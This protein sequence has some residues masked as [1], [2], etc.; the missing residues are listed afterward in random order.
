MNNIKAV[1]MDLDGTTLREDLT[2]SDNLKEKINEFEKK[3]IKFFVSTGRSYKSSKPYVE[4]LGLRNETI[5][6]NGA[7][8]VPANCI[9]N[10]IYEQPLSKEVVE[11][12]IDVS[13]S[14][15][16]HLNLYNN[17]DLYVENN[18]K[19][20]IAYA[21]GV[22]IDFI[23]D[24]FDNFIGKTSTKG[25]FIAENRILL[26]LKE[27]LENI[28]SEVNYVFSK[29]NYLEVLNKNVNKGKAVQYVLEKH[30]ISK[31]NAVAFGDQWNDYEML[32]TV[33]YGILMGNAPE[34]LKKKFSKNRITLSNDE[35]GIV[36]MLEKLFE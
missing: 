27:E 28:I 9:N 7:R 8:I 17:D 36:Y 2:I 30:G 11:K 20:A 24:N 16:I 22:G 35:D 18:S 15:K 1:F 32:E 23:L 5:T 34:E 13:R 26:A 6:Y 10:E 29:P 33:K 21:Q 19:E 4:E 25:L 12:L 3:G 31:E 14:K